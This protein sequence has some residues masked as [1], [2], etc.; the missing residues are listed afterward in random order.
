MGICSCKDNRDEIPELD[1]K[2]AEKILRNVFRECGILP[3]EPL[4]VFLIVRKKIEIKNEGRSF[5]E[6]KEI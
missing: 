6:Q 4:S 5:Y 2:T 1:T 3:P